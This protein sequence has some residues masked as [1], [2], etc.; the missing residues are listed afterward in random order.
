MN[1]LVDREFDAFVERTKNRPVATGRVSVKEACAGHCRFD[2]VRFPAGADDQSSDRAVINLCRLHHPA[3]SLHETPYLSA[4]GF[5]PGFAFSWGIPMA[6]AASTSTVPA[7]AWLLFAA[8]MLWVLIYDT[9]YAMVDR[10][11]DLRIGLK[12]TAILLDDADRLIIGIIQVMFIAALYSVGHQSG[13][14]TAYH[15]ALLLA[16]ALLTYQQ[17][18]I[19]DRTPGKCF[20]AFLSNNWV[21]LII[22]SGIALSL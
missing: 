1:D 5:S 13:L 8:N 7:M 22:F 9:I 21:G 17:Y 18:L 16:A 10:Q 3:L 2:T 15:V 11:D 4:S 6:Y 14:G 19:H 12:S 20:K